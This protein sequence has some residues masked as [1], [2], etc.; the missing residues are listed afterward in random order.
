MTVH[1]CI[2]I[3][4]AGIFFLARAGKLPNVQ[5]EGLRLLLLAALG[6]NLLGA[7]VTW[8]SG[9]RA[10]PEGQVRLEK[11]KTAS[12]K[13][14]E[15]VTEEE[16]E[17]VS[18][19]VPGR[20][21]EEEE[22]ETAP[23]E[24]VTF[25]RKLQEEADRLNQERQDPDYYY[26]PETVG[27]SRIL[28]RYPKDRSGVFLAGLSLLAG[29]LLLVLKAR[30][31]TKEAEKRREQ[32]LLDYPG[33]ILKFTLYVQ[34]GLPP[35]K[36]F[37][38]IAREDGKRRQDRPAMQE[39]TAMCREMESGMSE[40]EA[41]RRFGER[42]GQIRYR[43]FAALLTQNLKKGSRQLLEVLERESLEAWEERKRRARVQGES[44]G[45]RLLIPM[46]LMLVVVMAIVLIPAVFAFYGV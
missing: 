7:A 14:L 39:V 18:L 25:S 44:A 5:K 24:T 37:F 36:A 38:R 34:A 1:I 9:Q 3:F 4:L 46:I 21:T 19:L 6:G 11:Q 22:P 16:Q 17:E 45:T 33:L 10:L 8:Q 35:R 2:F 31:K 28:W 40:A 12:E 29:A 23:E 32:L 20:Q 27:G 15:A 30:E 26:L 41:Y 13:T 42:C 43:T